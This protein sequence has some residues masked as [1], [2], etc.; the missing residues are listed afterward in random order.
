MPRLGCNPGGGEAILAR[1]P[2]GSGY[3][4][5]GRSTNSRTCICLCIAV[6]AKVSCQ[7]WK[8]TNTCIASAV[9]KVSLIL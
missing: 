9:E 2:R 5:G 6:L 3:D 8:C 4:I 7:F 1:I